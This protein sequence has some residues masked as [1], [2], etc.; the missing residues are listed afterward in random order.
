MLFRFYLIVFSLCF[1][2]LPALAEPEEMVLK[3]E[4]LSL[5]VQTTSDSARG[6]LQFALCNHSQT[7][8]HIILAAL[9]GGGLQGVNQ[10]N[11]I[12]GSSE[13]GRT[14]TYFTS[15]PIM[16]LG[17]FAEVKYTWTSSDSPDVLSGIY[18]ISRPAVTLDTGEKILL[19]APIQIPR[20]NGRYRLT[21]HFDNRKLTGLVYSTGIAPISEFFEATDTA[22]IDIK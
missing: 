17:D 5:R 10:W 15:E 7:K 22:I 9:L 21:I 6:F 18:S 4:S 3:I 20:Q 12:Y 11:R 1:G 14:T 8:K 16:A 19:T 13:V 2:L